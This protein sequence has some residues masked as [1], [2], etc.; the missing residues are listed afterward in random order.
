MPEYPAERIDALT[1]AV[2][3]LLTGRAVTPVALPPEHPDDELRQL[4]GF[5]NDFMAD[6][7]ALTEYVLAV[8]RGELEAAVP[9]NRLKLTAAFKGLAANLRQLTWTAKRIAAGDFSQRVDFMGEFSEAFN[10]MTA[11]LDAAFARIA[12]QNEAMAR[13]IEERRLLE[14]EMR[15]GEQRI[16]SVLD[17]GIHAASGM[18]IVAGCL[19]ASLPDG[20]SDDSLELIAQQITRLAQTSGAHGVILDVSAMR[21]L[22]SHVF[23]GLA[24]LARTLGLLGAKTLFT[25]FQPGVVSALMDLDMDFS[26]IQGAINLEDAFERL[27]LTPP[28]REEDG[29]EETGSLAAPKTPQRGETDLDD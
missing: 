6:Y 15:R 13:E 9:R 11:D 1:A 26:G 10:K 4:A 7:A 3:G 20:L 19:I 25:G 12:S 17:A 22:D 5:L 23:A 18:N 16:Q 28:G 24:K 2:H 8:A 21:I 29:D 27:G 14:R